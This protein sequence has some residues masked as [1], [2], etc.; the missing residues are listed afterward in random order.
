M[1]G[2]YKV[3]ERR[4]LCIKPIIF[5][6]SYRARHEHI[7]QLTDLVLGLHRRLLMPTLAALACCR[8]P[9][10]WIIPEDAATRQLLHRVATACSPCLRMVPQREPLTLRVPAVAAVHCT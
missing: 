6:L 8:A 10:Q 9:C 5:P 1:R 3:T 7:V 4:M 2:T